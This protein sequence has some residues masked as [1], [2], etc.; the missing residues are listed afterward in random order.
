MSK[1]WEK[2]VQAVSA[3]QVPQL[4]R[5]WRV[6]LLCV[7]AALGSAISN[8]ALA[9]TARGVV[10]DDSTKRPLEGAI[11]TLLTAKGQDAGKPP[12]RTDT[13]GR[14]TLHAGEMGKYQLSVARIGYQPLKSQTI[15]FSFGGA[16]VN[17]TLN[18]TAA[19][20]KLGT[21]VV[22]GTGRLTNTELMSAEGFDLRKSKGEGKFLDSVELARYQRTP[23]A[24]LLEEN[25]VRYGLEFTTGPNGFDV[26]RMIRGGGFCTPEV[27][28]DG[29]ESRSASAVA[30][31][32]SLGA[33]EI[34]GIEVYSGFQLPAPSL[35]GEI[36]SLG[37]N[38]RPSQRC[39][40]VA[41]WTKGYAA[42]M[43]AKADK[44]KPPQI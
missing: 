17:L 25:K 12:V 16:V 37:Y 39:G 24:W 33:D 4:Y 29:F 19:P 1:V 34:Y 23:A 38:L 43:K 21:V 40:A 44:K 5:L 13:L 32:S 6:A 3:P 22:T 2:T 10:V 14:F 18:M 31:L 35:A 8:P 27:W 41:V 11:V 26:I 7:L 36:G 15:S 9:Q 42:E 28:I 30:R 20:T